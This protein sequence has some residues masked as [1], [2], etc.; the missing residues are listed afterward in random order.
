MD[1]EQTNLSLEQVLGVL[2]RRAPWIL[3]CFV[4]VAGAAYGFSKHQT[5]KYTATA[6]LVFNN[7]QLGQQVAGLP[8]GEQQQPAGPAEH[9]PQARPARRHGGED[10]GPA[11]PG[12]DRRKRSART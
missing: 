12:A 3:L 8:V 6:S 7:N 1:T 2:R 10:R 5:K 4:L 9:E 11:R